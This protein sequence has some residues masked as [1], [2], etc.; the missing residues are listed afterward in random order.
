MITHEEYMADSE[1][2]HVAFF[3]EIAQEAEVVIDRPEQYR[4]EL[5]RDPNLNTRGLPYWDSL[6]HPYRRAAATALRARGTFW[7]L[8]VGV[9]IVKAAI[10]D[11]LG[12]MP[13][14]IYG[15]AV[16]AG[17]VAG[18]HESDL[19]L[20]D[21]PEARALLER[22]GKTVDGWNVQPFT[23]ETDGERLLDVPFAYPT[24]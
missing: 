17:L 14:T 16:S 6:A 22:H 23:S 21:T 5:E 9:C 7:S 2:L 8:S 4:S 11:A 18:H 13:G 12:A 10:R 20:R 15:D 1:N 19:Y 24:A 3:A